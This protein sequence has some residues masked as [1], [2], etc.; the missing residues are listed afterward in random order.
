MTD[1]L[2]QVEAAY[3]AVARCAGRVVGFHPTLAELP[4]LFGLT[5]QGVTA[6]AAIRKA[7]A[8]LHLALR[9]TPA[10]QPRLLETT[11][12]KPSH[13]AKRVVIASTGVV[14]C[15][16][17]AGNSNCPKSGTLPLLSPV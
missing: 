8:S 12:R 1:E 4:A 14:V 5:T 16:C 17:A 3:R 6:G 13:S 10:L 9:Q 11:L 2:T 15:L 7:S